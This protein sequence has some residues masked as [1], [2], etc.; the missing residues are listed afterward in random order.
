MFHPKKPAPADS[1]S[2]YGKP[3][4]FCQTF[5]RDMKSFYLLIFL[6]TANHEEAERYFASTVEEGCDENSVFKPWIGSWIKRELIKKAIRV[7]FSRPRSDSQ[8]DVWY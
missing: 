7:V 6:L 4:D 1:R 3:A 8:R 5:E 2:D